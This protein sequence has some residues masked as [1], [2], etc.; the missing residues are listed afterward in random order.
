MKTKNLL[1]TAIAIF[2]LFTSTQSV[3]A[4]TG[5]YSP[6]LV[7]FDVAMTNLL[8][9]FDIPGGQLAIT[10]QGR[11][12]YS[13]GFGFADEST[14]T[15]VCPDNIFRIASLSKQITAITIMHLYEQG[16]VDLNDLVFGPN[17]I[18][19]EP[20]YQT[21]LD[22]RVYNIRV[23][24]LL[25]HQGGWD[26]DISGDP[27]H[28]SYAIAL[29]M[30]VPPPA[31]NETIIQYTLSQQMLDFTPGSSAAYS[32]LGFNILGEVIEKITSQD[33]ETYVRDSIL[34]TLGITDMHSAKSLLVNKYP[35]EVNYYDYPGAPLVSSV[36][37]NN[38]LG[39]M[40][41]GGSKCHMEVRAAAAGWVASAQD[42]CKL[43]CAVDLYP[44]KPDI[45]LPATINTMVQPVH[46]YLGSPYALGWYINTTDN[47][48]FHTGLLH[49]TMTFQCR[50]N[51]GINYALLVNSRPNL[52][53]AQ[54]TALND[55]VRSIVPL[56]TSWPTF[57]LFDSTVVCSP[58][59]SVNNISQNPS[60]FTVYPNPSNGKFTVNV[61]GLQQANCKL[62]ICNLVGQEIYTTFFKG[63]QS[64]LD[65]DL[66]DFSKGLYFVKVDD[67]KN[68]YTQKI[69]TE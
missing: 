19:P 12:V 25:S 53:S 2:L 69:I 23:K 63:H 66:S 64:T 58:L 51:D 67:G 3:K 6:S 22:T 10:Y 59:S 33:Y 36:F 60:L 34:A 1:I 31:N 32:N 8:N 44:T 35:N 46:S 16:R 37:N 17:G 52:Y 47:N 38:I 7:N 65:I 42:L 5:V 50:R 61:D 49:G 11:L 39:P 56:I 45:L 62:S 15:A 40:Q 29:A 68:S 13:R 43:L 55:L 26:R 48:W 41:Y 21:I 30:A 20:I 9:D 14:S 28:N 54:Y 57:D 4:Q 27:E 18:L 24:H